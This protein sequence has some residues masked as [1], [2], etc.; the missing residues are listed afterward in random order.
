V[1]AINYLAEI[2]IE[3]IMPEQEMYDILSGKMTADR[4]NSVPSRPVNN[5]QEVE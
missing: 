4:D 1:A 2:T 3:G 5:S